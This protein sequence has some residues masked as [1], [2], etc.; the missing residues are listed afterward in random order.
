MIDREYKQIRRILCDWQDLLK[1]TC[2]QGR[3]SWQHRAGKTNNKATGEFFVNKKWELIVAM[4]FR[5]LPKEEHTYLMVAF[6]KH[7]IFHKNV[8]FGEAL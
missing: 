7:M 8:G 6:I 1:W 3:H 5:F 4:T 2:G